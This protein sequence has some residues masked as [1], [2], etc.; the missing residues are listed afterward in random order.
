MT[1]T[2][3]RGH[4]VE[5]TYD[6]RTVDAM[7]VHASSNG[8]S[9]AVMFDAMLGPWAGGMAL[10]QHDDGTWHDLMSQLVDVKGPI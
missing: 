10:L 7:V 2:L 4:F 3:Q 5:L 1:T 9:I 6:G 8:R